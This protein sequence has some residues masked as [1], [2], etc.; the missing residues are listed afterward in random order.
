MTFL[1]VFAETIFFTLKKPSM[2]LHGSV[3]KP[4][5][6]KSLVNKTYTILGELDQE[7]KDS[8]ALFYEKACKMN[9]MSPGF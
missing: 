7:M 6:D 9:K 2:T 3:P 5:S 4:H 8:F 1:A